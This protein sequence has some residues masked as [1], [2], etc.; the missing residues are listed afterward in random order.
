MESVFKKIESDLRLKHIFEA[1]RPNYE[2]SNDPGH[3]LAH[4]YRVMSQALKIGTLE[5]AN[6]DILLPAAL[7]HDIVNVPKN[8][9]DRLLASRQA[10]E[11]AVHLL[12]KSSYSDQ[13]IEKIQQV[14]VEHS[15]SLG[16]KPSSLES[17]IMQDAD[18]LDAI[19]AIGIL[20]TASAGV[21]MGAKYYHPSQPFVEMN[22]DSKTSRSL[23]DRSFT[24]DH[25]HVKLYRLGEGF[26]TSTAQVEAKR[27]I[28]FMK[29]FE[30]ELAL[31]IAPAIDS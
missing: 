23:D 4:I 20:R 21:R 6:L 31:E 16:L 9:P 5:G 12:Q 14:I 15:F 30:I 25:F 24:L 3:D 7:L 1:V 8:H 17:K 22:T 26:H 2:N 11:A 18:R 19:G 29:Q 28:S 10:A 13:E 27:R